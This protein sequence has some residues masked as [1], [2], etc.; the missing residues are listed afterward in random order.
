[1]LEEFIR[2]GRPEFVILQ[3]GADSVAGD[4]ITHMRFSPAAHTHAARRLSTLALELCGGRFIATG[5]GGYNRA[6]LAAAWCG[7]V[8]GMLG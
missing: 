5:G 7:V 3:A 4:P 1:M 2:A 8:E 6:S